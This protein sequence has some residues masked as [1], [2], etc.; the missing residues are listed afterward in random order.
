MSVRRLRA[1]LSPPEFRQPAPQSAMSPT[2][3]LEN[4][5]ETL[6]GRVPRTVACLLRWLRQP[7]S[8]LVRIPI[9][10]VLVLCGLLGFLPILGFWMVPLGLA[11]IAIDVPF[12]RPPLAHLL[13][14]I[15]RK[16][17]KAD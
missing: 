2:P 17:K 14:Y 15:N 10:I 1:P 13:A 6:Q 3:D 8:R 4:E 11:V 5:L 9:G 7:F 16:W 12:L